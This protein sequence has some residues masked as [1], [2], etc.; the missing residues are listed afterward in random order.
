MGDV[1]HEMGEGL[2]SPGR[3]WKV[4]YALLVDIPSRPTNW[5]VVIE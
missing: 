2:P 5:T 1:R 4:M 3:N